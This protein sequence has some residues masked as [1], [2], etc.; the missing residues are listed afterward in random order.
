MALI[1]C[2][3]CG[4]Q[5]SD[6]AVACPE[7]G[8]PKAA[9]TPEERMAGLLAVARPP[10][11]PSEAAGASGCGWIG[12][13]LFLLVV[14]GFVCFGGFGSEETSSA[15]SQS[16]RSRSCESAA[17]QLASVE[18]LHELNEMSPEVQAASSTLSS[19][20]G[21][22]VLSPRVVAGMGTA[23]AQATGLQLSGLDMLEAIDRA[24]ATGSADGLNTA[25]AMQVILV[26]KG[27]SIDEAAA[28]AAASLGFKRTNPS[29][30]VLPGS[31]PKQTVNTKSIVG[32]WVVESQSGSTGY[33]MT[34]RSNNTVSSK[35]YGSEFEGTWKHLG[36]GRYHV[37]PSAPGDYTVLKN[38]RLEQWDGQGFIRRFKRAD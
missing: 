3:D 16:D 37:E 7:C 14:V 33:Q 2:P 23:A 25:L 29:A 26:K 13:I 9:T 15:P 5:H 32:K 36:N 34:Y 30:N 28:Q 10:A 1:T 19:L 17:C 35:M 24:F 22:F 21:K 11:Q 4:K 27:A 8:R 12:A 38:G 20:G 6:L 18:A 31:Q